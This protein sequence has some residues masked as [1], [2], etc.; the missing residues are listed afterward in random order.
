MTLEF[1]Q[2]S[3]LRLTNYITKTTEGPK[4]KTGKYQSALLLVQKVLSYLGLSYI[5]LSAYDLAYRQDLE[6]IFSQYDLP[7]Q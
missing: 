6:L 7:Y 5:D 3:F 4:L 2:S 1:V